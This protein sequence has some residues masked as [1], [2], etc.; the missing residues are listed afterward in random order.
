MRSYGDDPVEEGDGAGGG[1][2]YY[3]SIPKNLTQLELWWESITRRADYSL[4]CV[5][6]VTKNDTQAHSFISDN[7]EELAVI[8]GKECCIIFFRDETKAENFIKWE[9]SEHEK[10]AIP[11]AQLIEADVPSLVFFEKISSGKFVT[12]SLRHKN[13]DQLLLDVRGLFSSFNKKSDDSPL[14][15]ISSSSKKLSAT[16]FAKKI[17]GKTDVSAT[18]FF[19][20]I[21]KAC[22]NLLG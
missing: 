16:N 11:F 12:V 2:G 19:K 5:A 14:A 9:F 17:L 6:L 21:G 10:I 1:G 18:E 8:S 3:R 7:M 22:G 4:Y 13:S 20:A 15:R